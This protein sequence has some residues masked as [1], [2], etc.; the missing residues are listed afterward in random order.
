MRKIKHAKEEA[1][2][3]FDDFSKLS[4]MVHDADTA[5]LSSVIKLRPLDGYC[6]QRQHVLL[7]NFEQTAEIRHHQD[8]S[9]D[10]YRSMSHVSSFPSTRTP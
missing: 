4:T 10:T 8:A 2:I 9:K 5:G 3:F 1:G 6:A 7:G